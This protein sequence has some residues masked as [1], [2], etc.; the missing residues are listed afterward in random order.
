VV[1]NLCGS[2]CRSRG[3]PRDQLE[4]KLCLDWHFFF[5]SMDQQQILAIAQA[6]VQRLAINNN[7]DVTPSLVDNIARQVVRRPVVAAAR[8]VVR[9]PVVAAAQ[10]G[11]PNING[12]EVLM[13]RTNSGRSSS[14]GFS[15][16]GTPQSSSGFS[17]ATILARQ[18]PPSMTPDPASISRSSSGVSSVS[19]SSSMVTPPP[20][21]RQSGVQ[22]NL[23]FEEV[24]DE[25][26]AP[27][28]KRKKSDPQTAAIV[29]TI[30]RPIMEEMD[31]KLLAP[32]VSPL[33]KK[34]YKR[35]RVNGK[36]ALR[37]KNE[38]DMVM[39]KKLIRPIL[40]RLLGRLL[41]PVEDQVAVY[42][43]YYRVAIQIVKKR[44]ANHIQSWRVHGKPK[45]ACYDVLLPPFHESCLA[46]EASHAMEDR[47]ESMGEDATSQRQKDC[48]DDE[49]MD[50]DE[51]E[52][53]LQ[54]GRDYMDEESQVQE[55]YDPLIDRSDKVTCIDCKCLIPK[56]YSFPQSVQ[57]WARNKDDSNRCKACWTKFMQQD[58]AEQVAN[59]KE[60]ENMLCVVTGSKKRKVTQKNKTRR[61]RGRI[62]R[63]KWCNS[64]T[65]KTK[66]SKKC[67]FNKLTTAITPAAPAA[68]DLDSTATTPAPAA[69]D[70]DSTA[71]TPAPAAEDVDSTATTPAPAAEDVDL[72]TPVPAAEDVDSTTTT[73]VPAVEDVDSTT[74]APADQ[75]VSTPPPP[76]PHRQKYQ[77]GDNVLGEWRRN[78]WFLAHVTGFKQGRYELYFPDDGKVK[79]R[80]HAKHV[81]P[82]PT[83][84][85][86]LKNYKRGDMIDKVFFD[87]GMNKSGTERVMAEGMWKVRRVE[88][89]EYVCLRSSD[90][91]NKDETPNCMKYDIGYVIRQREMSEQNER[92]KF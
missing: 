63:C 25:V 31:T 36:R 45:K 60:R 42:S 12:S 87:D 68:E 77:I 26:F 9:Q 7:S 38:M 18:G 61:K 11:T 39:F 72:T 59:D 84:S 67:P 46:S 55:E 14:S 74:T 82:V 24:E 35:K 8:Q 50:Q 32:F 48:G 58:V 10:Q 56:G 19:V 5:S 13:S 66:R 86:G 21:T 79:L 52:S 75:D 4:V 65:H 30:T 69:E 1:L 83:T 70:L 49:T 17:A 85:N 37:R 41:L 20:S 91:R 6:V 88:G 16:A 53:Q 62:T 33:F 43:K 51:E 15:S 92:N 90:C 23:N 57:V 71:T 76:K 22:R 47:D 28:Q 3:L 89:N 73:P 80:V 40:R 27:K 29:Q 44:R 64:T 2:L 34:F 81:K 54:E 78:K